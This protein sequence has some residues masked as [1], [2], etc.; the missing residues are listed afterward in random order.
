MWVTIKNL[1]LDQ[2]RKTAQ[3]KP[4]AP[5][6]VLHVFLHVKNFT[7]YSC[8]YLFYMAIEFL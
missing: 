2:D 7:M 1:K 5:R 6:V 8:I 4:L 3:E